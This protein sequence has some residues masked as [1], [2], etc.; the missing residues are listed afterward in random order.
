MTSA[1]EHRRTR[2]PGLVDD[3]ALY[4][5][6]PATENLVLW[7]KADTLNGLA[8]GDPVS[9][10]PDTSGCDHHATQS[11]ST[12]QP[13]YRTNRVNGLPALYFDAT[14]DR[15]GTPLVIAS[16]FTAFAVYCQRDANG[17]RRAVQG[18]TNWLIG[19]YGGSYRYYNGAHITGDAVTIG[20]FV[21]ASVI[22]TEVSGAYWLD[23]GLVGA[24]G[25]KNAPG[26]VGLGAQGAYPDVLGG[27]I[28]EV[29]F[30]DRALLT[31]ER[32]DVE[33][34]LKAKYSL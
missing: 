7:L 29:L 25:N 6:L 9:S 4:A 33:A 21:Y 14:N 30:Y 5:G 26:T 28:A 20:R 22:Q 32:Q 10:W 3:R 27:D 8:D 24:N 15:M 17:N 18:S 34:Y 1:R 31:S 19:P 11:N 13:L 23:G 16:P 12:Y 2:I